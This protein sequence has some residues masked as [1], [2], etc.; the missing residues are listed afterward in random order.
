MFVLCK[1]SAFFNKKIEIRMSDIKRIR[2]N[3]SATTTVKMRHYMISEPHCSVER[4]HSVS[5]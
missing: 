2:A 3:T 5:K 1:V 4:A